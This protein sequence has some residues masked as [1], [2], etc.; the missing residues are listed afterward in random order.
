M[1]NIFVATMHI[2]SRSQNNFSGERVWLDKRKL[3]K[4]LRIS[5]DKFYFIC[6]NLHNKR[7][8]KNKIIGRKYGSVLGIIAEIVFMTKSVCDYLLCSAERFVCPEVH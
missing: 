7:K 1:I 6:T 8:S 3:G 5:C 4:D 2:Y